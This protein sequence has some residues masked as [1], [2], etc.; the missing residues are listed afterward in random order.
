MS[1]NEAQPNRLDDFNSLKSILPDWDPTVLAT[2]FQANDYSLELSIQTALSM[3][4]EEG[5]PVSNKITSEKEVLNTSTSSPPPTA[6]SA[7]IISVPEIGKNTA[8]NVD[9]GDE[10]RSNRYR[11]AT[12]ELPEEFLRVCKQRIYSTFQFI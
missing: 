8:K 12:F 2:I 1:A 7:E 5:K 11:G 9:D 4:E 3:Q 10:K 6:I